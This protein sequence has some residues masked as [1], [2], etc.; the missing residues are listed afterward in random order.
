[1]LEKGLFQGDIEKRGIKIEKIIKQGCAGGVR[2]AVNTK[3]PVTI[4][5]TIRRTNDIYIVDNTN[6][7]NNNN[8]NN[9]T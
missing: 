6:D 9:L 7:Y 8:N 4:I 2:I 1:M 5:M 3:N